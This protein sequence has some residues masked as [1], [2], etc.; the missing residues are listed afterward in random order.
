MWGPLLQE[1][2]SETAGAAVPGPREQRGGWGLRLGTEGTVSCPLPT[3]AL[4]VL[5]LSEGHLLTQGPHASVPQAS[6][7]WGLDRPG[8]SSRE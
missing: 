8:S 1:D 2:R 3:P 7:T 4:R 5:T 6:C